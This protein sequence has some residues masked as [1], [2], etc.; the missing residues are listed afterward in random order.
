MLQDLMQ[1]PKPFGGKT[2]VFSGDYQQTLPIMEHMSEE[3]VLRH[4]AKNAKVFRDHAQ[5]HTLVVNMRVKLR[6][7]ELRQARGTQDR[8]TARRRLED[9][10]RYSEFTKKMGTGTLPTPACRNIPDDFVEVPSDICLAREE[11]DVQQTRGRGK[12][13]ADSAKPLLD[14]VFPSFVKKHRSRVYLRGRAILAPRNDTT[15]AINDLCLDL[16]PGEERTYLSTDTVAE[17]TAGD[18]MRYAP[19][20]EFLNQMVT[21]NG[22]PHHKVRLKVGALVMVLRSIRGEPRLVNG[23][24][25]IVT[26]LHDTCIEA[27]IVGGTYDGEPVIIHTIPLIQD[28][29][30]GITTFAV[31]RTQLPI[32]LSWAMTINKVR[33]ITRV[34]RMH[35]LGV[36]ARSDTKGFTRHSFPHT[37]HLKTMHRRLPPHSLS[38]SQNIVPSHSHPA[39]YPTRQSQGQTLQQVGLYFQ[40]Q[41]FSHGQ[42]YVAFSRVGS[43]SQIRVMVD[44]DGAYVDPDHPD[45]VFIRNRVQRCVLNA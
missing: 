31:K 1:N 45:K 12:I 19:T 36:A 25:C 11:N 10:R 7:Q 17:A 21:P 39:S 18:D 20:T 2:I 30:F 15:F 34:M 29:D 13:N 35:T 43:F 24:R 5:I 8:A 27:D 28:R 38:T 6:A 33:P 41:C 14:F 26:D 44:D 42:C 22:F 37:P 3:R 16:V 40:S 9:Q 32:R 23:T 4:V